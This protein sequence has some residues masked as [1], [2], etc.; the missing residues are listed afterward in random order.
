M[1]KSFLEIQKEGME[2]LG[3]WTESYKEVLLNQMESM[4]NNEVLREWAIGDIVIHDKK[5]LLKWHKRYRPLTDEEIKL[6]YD[7]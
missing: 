2:V 6:K 1:E 4:Y 7:R 3:F 5:V